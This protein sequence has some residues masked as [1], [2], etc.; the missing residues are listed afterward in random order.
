MNKEIGSPYDR[1]WDD[2]LFDRDLDPHSVKDGVKQH[3]LTG[4]LMLEYIKG[5]NDAKEFYRGTKATRRSA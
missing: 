3:N 2:W 4:D 5:W 1:G